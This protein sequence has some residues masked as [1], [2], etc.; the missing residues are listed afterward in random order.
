VI[1]TL[2]AAALLPALADDGTLFTLQDP[3]ITESSGL[4]ETRDP[5]RVVT[6]NDSGDGPY[7]YVIDPRTGRTVGRTTYDGDAVDVEAVT[8]GRNREIWVGD[9]GDNGAVRAGVRIYRLP[10]LTDGDREVPS[11]AYDLAYRGG[12]RDAE[13]LLVHPRTGRVYVVSKSLF[14]GQV[15][16]APARLRDDRPNLLR[17]VGRTPGIITDG[18]FFPDGRH[19]VLRDYSR[20]FLFD[21][22]ELPWRRI[23]SV[24]LPNQPQGEGID[25]RAG[26]RSLLVSTE[27]ANEPVQ[28]VALPPRVLA[29]LAPARPG[30][31]P[32]PGDEPQDESR[33]DALTQ[34]GAVPW[35]LVGGV[36]GICA[37]LGLGFRV[38]RR[39][40]RSTG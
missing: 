34:E 19:A 32:T 21:T 27:G 17:P 13:A 23:D 33:L 18:A 35:T 36:V 37:L 1:G 20:A 25:V 22:T 15:F 7:V 16:E 8:R 26:G 6:I 28:V 12:A 10:R 5:H 9:I 29:E 24:E 38:A 30:A 14:G 39:R 2:L 3:A 40:S 11:T 31:S 4:V